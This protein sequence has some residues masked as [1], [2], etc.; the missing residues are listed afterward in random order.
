MRFD[1]TVNEF[2]RDATLNQKLEIYGEQFWRP[3]C[4]VED[5]ANSCVKVLEA[6]KEKIRQNVFNVGDTNENYQKKMIAEMIINIVPNV[7]VKYV[8]KDEDPR[9]YRV[10]F[11]KIAKELNFKITKTALDGLKEIHKALLDGIISE[12]YS[13]H[14]KNI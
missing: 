6:P 4:H 3:Y 5:L 9:N 7:I 11:S 12:P 8:H 2:M 14:Y 1:L 10:D 13:N